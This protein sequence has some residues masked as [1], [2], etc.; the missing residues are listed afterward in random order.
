MNQPVTQA[1]TTTQVNVEGQTQKAKRGACGGGC[2][3]G[4]GGGGCGGCC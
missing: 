4:C 3:D 2:D 1:P